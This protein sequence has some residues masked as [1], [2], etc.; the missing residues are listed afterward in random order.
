MTGEFN[1]TG[2]IEDTTGLTLTQMTELEK[3]IEFY[4]NKYTYKGNSMLIL[5]NYRRRLI[6]F[7]K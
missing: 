6:V 4:D 1:E 3:W 5:F 7:C 2:L